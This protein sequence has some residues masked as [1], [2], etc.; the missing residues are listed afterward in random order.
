MAQTPKLETPAFTLGEGTV[1]RERGGWRTNVQYAAPATRHIDG[2]FD[3][4]VSA[5][6]FDAER[7]FVARATASSSRQVLANRAA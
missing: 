1:T 3:V 5:I 2:G 6:P 7:R 4:S